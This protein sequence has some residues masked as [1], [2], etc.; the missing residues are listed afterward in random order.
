MIN[1]IVSIPGYIQLYRSLLRFYYGSEND[2][3]EMLYQ[4]N[5]AR[6]RADRRCFLSGST[7][8][9]TVRTARKYSSTRRCS[10][11]NTV[12]NRT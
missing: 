11:Y 12:L 10:V 4:L 5:T 2:I 7:T 8:Q 1:H 6:C 3:K 9:A